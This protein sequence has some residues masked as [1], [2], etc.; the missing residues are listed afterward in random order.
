MDA[1]THFKRITLVVSDIDK[2]LKIYRDVL[3]FK[4]HKIFDSE[5]D[6]YSYPVF[7]IP[8]E[9]K[10]RFCTLDSSDQIRTIALTEVKGIELPK[11]QSPIMTASVIRVSNLTEVMLKIASLG[12]EYT[13]Q[14][15]D[16][17]SDSLFKEQSFI[18]F[19]GHLIVLYEILAQ[20]SP[21]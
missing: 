18:D 16:E 13:E 20:R 2:S 14:K 11:S 10:I 3:G 8:K 1:A 17:G 6:S 7:K 5:S 21:Q 19:D 12:L 9:A 15:I 4:V